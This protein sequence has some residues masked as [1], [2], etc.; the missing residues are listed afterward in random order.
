MKICRFPVKKIQMS[1]FSYIIRKL[2]VLSSTSH[3]ATVG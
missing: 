1:T 2:A 3:I